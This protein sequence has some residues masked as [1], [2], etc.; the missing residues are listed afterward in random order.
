MDVNI[1]VSVL[2]SVYNGERFLSESIDSI[3]NQTFKNYEFII[4]NDG[5]TD[6]SGEILHNYVDKDTRIILIK[7]SNKGLTYSLNKGI[8]LAR[9]KYIARMDAD[10]I[11]LPIRL[12]EEYKALTT[13]PKAVLVACFF[14]IINKNGNIIR[15]GYVPKRHI[16]RLLLYK[17]RL[18]HSSVMFLKEIFN[19]IGR[20]KLRYAQDYDLWL[21]LAEQGDIVV[22]D[23]ILHRYRYNPSGISV[24]KQQ[25]QAFCANLA[26]NCVL[27]RR[28][29]GNESKFIE[30][31]EKKFQKTI[32]D[33]FMPVHSYMQDGLFLLDTGKN[34]E[35]RISFVSDLRASK[36]KNLKSLFYLTVALFPK[37]FYKKIRKL[38]WKI[39]RVCWFDYF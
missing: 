19:K 13:N 5:S 22:I 7:Q 38:I 35:A 1:S 31:Q 27:I 14:E 16:K 20:Y 36:G 8:S 37:I 12:E 10:D 33:S 9:G 39:K 30:N 18:V 29:G 26:K 2:M 32:F 28:K 23:K 34:R 6:K 25:E 24:T 21:R 4:I 11:S 3:L 15:P 17:N